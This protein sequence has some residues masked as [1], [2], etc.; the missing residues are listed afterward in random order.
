VA[1]FSWRD[2]DGDFAESS[3]ETR[4]LSAS[5]A[6]ID[7]M[8]VP[9]IGVPVHVELLVRINNTETLRLEGN[10]TVVR[11]D[12]RGFAVRKTLSTWKMAFEKLS[13]GKIISGQ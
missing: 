1:H 9:P 11:V 4:D 12:E 6:F 7:T 5:G 8:D 13:F 2:A 10:A 3:G